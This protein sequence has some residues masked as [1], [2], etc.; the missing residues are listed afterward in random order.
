MKIVA[1]LGHYDTP[2]GIVPESV[3]IPLFFIVPPILALAICSEPFASVVAPFVSP[4]WVLRLLDPENPAR[5]S[6]RFSWRWL[7]TFLGGALV[8][9]AISTWATSSNSAAITGTSSATCLQVLRT[10]TIPWVV[11]LISELSLCPRLARR[12]CQSALTREFTNCQYR[13][14]NQPWIAT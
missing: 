5:G 2:S 12:R 13:R 11:V 4:L 7:A 6:W 14:R 8:L 10:P 3:T 9:N 1:R